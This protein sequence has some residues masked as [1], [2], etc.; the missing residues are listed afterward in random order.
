MKDKGKSFNYNRQSY[1]NPI[2]EAKEETVEPEVEVISEPIDTSYEGQVNGVN[3]NV[4]NGAGF[5]Y[6]VVSVVPINT[7]VKILEEKDGWGKIDEDKWIL[8]QYVKKI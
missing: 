8:L 7:R 6:G 3:L 1:T 4:R 2:S 5:E